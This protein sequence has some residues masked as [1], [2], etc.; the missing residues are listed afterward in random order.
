LFR[1][2]SNSNSHS[3]DIQAI[4]KALC[5]GLFYQIAIH[6]HHTVGEYKLMKSLQ[7]VYIHPSSVLAKQCQLDHKKDGNSGGTGGTGAGGEG[8]GEEK[9]AG[10]G[11]QQELPHWLMYY[12]LTFTTKEYMRT[13]MGIQGEWIMEIAPHYYANHTNE[14][15]KSL[16]EEQSKDRKKNKP[17]KGI[18]KATMD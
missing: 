12:E 9:G 16:E 17:I 7:I 8:E 13:V 1:I 6:S 5:S 2:A 15:R 3:I 10:S 14:I 11:G 4:G 18:G